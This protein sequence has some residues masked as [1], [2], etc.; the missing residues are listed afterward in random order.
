[1]ADTAE[2]NASEKKSTLSWSQPPVTVIK[3]QEAT[4]VA[5]TLGQKKRSYNN[6]INGVW[7]GSVSIVLIALIVSS[8]N[9]LRSKPAVKKDPEALAGVHETTVDGENAIANSPSRLAIPKTQKAGMMVAV[10]HVEVSTPTWVVV[11][12]NKNGGR[13]PVLGAALFDKGRIKGVVELLRPTVQGKAYF[14]GQTKDD[15]D[16]MYSASHDTIENDASGKQLLVPFTA[17]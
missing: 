6:L 11:Y 5:S 3:S 7:I 10:A 9:M 12:E 4:P 8:I 1:M 13:G 2:K 14:V 17:N 16:R 15:G